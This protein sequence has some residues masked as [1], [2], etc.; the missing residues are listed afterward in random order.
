M[1]PPDENGSGAVAAAHGAK[2]VDI[3]IPTA[4]TKPNWHNLS[5]DFGG[6]AAMS[7]AKASA[8]L[9]RIGYRHTMTNA[10]VRAIVDS[11]SPDNCVVFATALEMVANT[12][13]SE[14]DELR[15]FVVK[16]ANGGGA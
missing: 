10:E 9:M 6:S 16:R 13:Q 4:P 15:A 8:L 7:V 2:V 1:R 5:N 3:G 12:S 14:A 11:L